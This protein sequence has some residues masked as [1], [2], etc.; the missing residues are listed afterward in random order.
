MKCEE[1]RD[2]LSDYLDKELDRNV[3]V[4]VDKHLQICHNCALELEQLKTSLR[5][6]EQLKNIEP[7]RNFLK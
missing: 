5:I 2:L 7:P 1:I 3:Q 6:L 4:K